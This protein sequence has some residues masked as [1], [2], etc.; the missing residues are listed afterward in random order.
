MGQDG[1]GWF[2][3]VPVFSN[4]DIFWL[5][6]PEPCGPAALFILLVFNVG[7]MEPKGKGAFGLCIIFRYLPLSL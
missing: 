5:W 6:P 7:S 1:S 3:M 2:W 4:T